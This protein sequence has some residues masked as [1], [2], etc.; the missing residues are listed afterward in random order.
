MRLKVATL[1][2]L[3][4]VTLSSPTEA[5]VIQVCASTHGNTTSC[6]GTGIYNPRTGDGLVAVASRSSDY[7]GNFIQETADAAAYGSDQSYRP[8]LAIE[9]MADV[10]VSAK[11]DDD[12]QKSTF[13]NYH[14]VAS[15]VIST[16]HR[17][18]P[19]DDVPDFLNEIP[20]NLFIHWAMH[21]GGEPLLTSAAASVYV[22]GGEKGSAYIDNTKGPDSD[23][24]TFSL[25]LRPYGQILIS[26]SASASITSLI[27]E[28]EEASASAV[29][30]PFM[31]IDPAWEYAQYFVVEQESLDYPG[32]WIAVT[33]DWQNAGAIP[34]P[35]T[36]LLIGV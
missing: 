35:G 4:W 30:D 25:T 12:Y 28:V 11:R 1:F 20:V 22:G 2:L 21:V 3:P 17:V 8:G 10:Q 13:Y 6:G 34:E 9:P 27:R 26:A 5:A 24:G 19:L 15:S 32:T 23:S 16:W 36:L 31:Y 33:R 18:R 29:A 7:L 14:A